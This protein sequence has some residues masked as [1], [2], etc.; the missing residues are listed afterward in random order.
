MT[1]AASE[2]RPKASARQAAKR[3]EMTKLEQYQHAIDLANI[4]SKT[5]INGVITFVNNELC[6]VSGYTKNELIGKTH[7]ILRHPSVSDETF[8]LMWETILAGKVYKGIAKNKAKD[9]KIF[10]LDTTIV[11]ILDDGGKIDEFIAIRHDVTGIVTLNEELL[12]AGERIASEVALNDEKTRMM[13]AQNRLASLGE[14]LANI[15]HQWRQPLNELSINLY[16][17]K[18]AKNSDDKFAQTYQDAKALIRWMSDN[19]DDFRNFYRP[20]SDKSAFSLK[21]VINSTKMLVDGTI[22]KQNIK[23]K[24]DKSIEKIELFGYKNE[25]IQVFLNI[26]NNAKDAFINSDNTK[27]LISVSA[28]TGHKYAI[29]NISDNAG[30]INESVIDKV[31]D[32]YFTTKHQKVGKDQTVGT[33]LGLYMSQKIIDKMG[34]HI[35]VKNIKNGCTFEIKLPLKE[36]K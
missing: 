24:L 21:S 17:L 7:A 27:K 4:V 32:P 5:D 6:K 22:K 13:F 1:E 9:G 11:P 10:Y 3:R 18:M 20:V 15:A 34:G 25:L 26:F 35:S 12:N 33:G 36:Q 31:F 14:M 8:R 19:I 29:I 28:K 16:Q 2:A 30:G 23:V